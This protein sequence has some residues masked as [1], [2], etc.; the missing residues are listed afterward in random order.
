[1]LDDDQDYLF[2]ND[3]LFDNILHDNH[4]ARIDHIRDIHEK[5]EILLLAFDNHPILTIKFDHLKI[6]DMDFHHV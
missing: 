3:T 6:V 4:L 5:N 2:N 1:M